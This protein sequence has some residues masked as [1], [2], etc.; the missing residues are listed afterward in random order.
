MLD[1]E[2]II[3]QAIK[4]DCPKLSI[5]KK[6]IWETTYRGIYP[7]EKID[8]YD[9]SENQ[10]KFKNFIDNASQ[11]LY[12]VEDK[13]E[14]IGYIEF[15]EPHRPF[16]DY[17]QEIGLFYIREDYQRQGLGRKLFNMAYDYIKNTGVDKFFISCH[18]YN[19]NAQKF[20]EKMGGKV[21]QLDENSVSD[22]IPQIKYE[23][24]VK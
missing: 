4:E 12:V 2:L 18:K 8:N 14:L 22:G 13:N 3:R 1:N 7:D 6:Q 24:I 11:Q 19:T 5:L 21:V 17:S 20:Y 15:G 10:K 9:Y 23:Y 16:Q